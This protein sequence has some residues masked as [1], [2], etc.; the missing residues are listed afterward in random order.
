M[1]ELEQEGKT[2]PKLDISVNKISLYSTLTKDTE[3]VRSFTSPKITKF[4]LKIIVRIA[5]SNTMITNFR[6]RL[7]TKA[8]T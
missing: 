7:L 3:S 8:S 1:T 2:F 6:V 5:D 4:G